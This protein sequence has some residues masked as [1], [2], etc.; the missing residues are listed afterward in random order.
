VLAKRSL[1][2]AARFAARRGDARDRARH[3]LYGVLCD[4]AAQLGTQLSR[5]SRRRLALLGF[6]PDGPSRSGFSSR[7]RA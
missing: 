3:L 4:A 5:R 2:M 1:E 7:H 6:A